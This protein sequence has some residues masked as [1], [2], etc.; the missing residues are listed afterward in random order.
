MPPPGREPVLP[1]AVAALIEVMKDEAPGDVR[2]AI[3]A[4]VM[5]APDR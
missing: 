3:A 2:T 4:V 1:A 5:P